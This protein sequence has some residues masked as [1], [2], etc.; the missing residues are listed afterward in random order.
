MGKCTCNIT[1]YYVP[2]SG[3]LAGTEIDV[4][5]ESFYYQPAEKM[6]RAYPGC[7]AE[8]YIEEGDFVATIGW[9]DLE[10]TPHHFNH[11]EGVNDL[12]DAILESAQEKLA[13]IKA[14]ENAA[15]WDFR[16]DMY[17]EERLLGG[18]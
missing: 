6:T 13:E 14:G 3:P 4:I 8:I 7:D 17:R 12:C 11:G 5:V 9:R 16:R 18:W 10:L 2:E 15:Y 1:T